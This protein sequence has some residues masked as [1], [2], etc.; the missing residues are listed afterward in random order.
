MNLLID[1]HSIAFRAFYA[2]PETLVTSKGFPTNVI[3]GFLMMLSKLTSSYDCEKLIVTWD[4]SKSTFRTEMYKEYKGNRKSAPDNFKIQ[5]KALQQILS[6]FNIPQISLDGFEADDVLGTLSKQFD[7]KEEKTLIVTGDRD[8]YQLISKNINILYTKRGISN[9]DVYDEKLFIE[10]F[11]I[12]VE[13]YIEYLALKGDPSDN[14]PGL[15]GVGEKTAINLLL[16]HKNIK[17]I[18]NNLGSLTP[19]LQQTFSENSELLELSK[20][21]ATIKRDL[22]IEIPKVNFS[23]TIF[24]NNN[25]LESSADLIN[26]YELNS[27]FKNTKD[28]SSVSKNEI[29]ELVTYEYKIKQESLVFSYQDKN[30]F[31]NEEEVG[32][33][34]SLEQ[35]KNPISLTSQKLLNNLS[36]IK[37]NFTALDCMLFLN[38]PS[39]RPDNLINIIKVINPSEFVDKKTTDA[40]LANIIQKNYKNFIT[41][42]EKISKD[43]TLMNIYKSIDF[44][45]MHV[46]AKM[47]NLGVNVSLSKMKKLS[48][49]LAKDLSD[50]EK[51]I[52]KI[53]KKD[54]NI[55]SPKQLAEVLYEDLKMPIV[56]TTPKGAPSTDA[57]VLEELSKNYELPKLILSYRELEKIRSTYV[58]GLIPL[59]SNESKIHT[60]YNLF[61]TATG[62]LSSEQP[63]LQNIPNK[64]QIGQK[65]RDFFIPTEGC[66]FIISD[67]SQ[68]E[69]RVLAHLS[70]DKNM[71]SILQNRESDIHSETA[72]KIFNTSLSKVDKNMRRKA[73]EVNFGLIYGMEAFGLS[74][75]LKIS[76]KE[77]SELIE[78]YFLQFPKIKGFLDDIVKN[79][80]KNTYTETLSGRKRYVRE[81]SSSNFQVKSMGKRI[82]MNAPIQGTAADIMKIAMI[83][84]DEYLKQS[85]HGQ[86]ILQIHDEIV[87]Q[88]EN[89]F[90]ES[91]MDAITKEMENAYSLKVPIFVNSKISNSLANFNN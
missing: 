51:D 31:V 7:E 63:N 81:L 6:E 56:K 91:A 11:K 17:N 37:Q 68:I 32:I 21:L 43:K 53:S 73:K 14:I 83:K 19:K 13:Q 41:Q 89:T 18:Y 75:S 61:G 66:S 38:D 44:P 16:E 9:T 65:I 55:N 71:V 4:V 78:A 46:L 69:L 82:A 3:H 58:D 67:Y 28:K 35:F 70:G 49:Q 59:V 57:S 74:K 40:E 47:E 8:S 72:S 84:V 10:K 15:P 87:V 86:L 39:T 25:V 88:V 54:F 29:K 5:I 48:K 45:V 36:N 85:G 20:K 80:E 60:H 42:Y 1:G 23:E 27:F 33:F 12:N 77:A 22:E 30:I 64:S 90:A 26:E 79:A 76:Q 34:T 62:R 24:K 2:L 52:I 50:I